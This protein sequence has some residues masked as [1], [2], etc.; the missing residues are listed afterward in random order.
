[1]C[2]IPLQASVKQICSIHIIV[3]L[4]DNENQG[5]VPVPASLGNGRDLAGNLYRGV[6]CGVKTFFRKSLSWEMVPLIK[7]PREGILERGIF[8][9]RDGATYIVADACSRY[10]KCSDAVARKLIVPGSK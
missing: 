9:S 5:I 7:N 4:C 6:S 8:V 2:V 10:Q 3:A 1:M